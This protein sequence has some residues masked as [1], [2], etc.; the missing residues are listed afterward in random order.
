MNWKVATG[1][2][3]VIATTIFLSI[4]ATRPRVPPEFAGP[5]QTAC[6]KTPKFSIAVPQG[7]D[8]ILPNG[9]GFEM[10]GFGWLAAQVCSPGTLRVI[11]AGDSADGVGARMDVTLNTEWLTS[12][13]FSSQR[14]VVIQIPKA[15]LLKLAFTND[16]HIGKEDRNLH[17]RDLQ[18]QGQVQ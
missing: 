12:E 10:N 8:T 3:P 11:A 9:K 4:V 5:I 1:L 17:V 2:L 16:V 7:P 18:F 6:E 13:T 15:G 14:N